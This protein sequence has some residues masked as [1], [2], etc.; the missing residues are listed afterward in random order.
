MGLLHAT[1]CRSW[2]FLLVLFVLASAPA[3]A[4]ID[5][6]QLP[7]SALWIKPHAQTL[8]EAELP[9]SVDPLAIWHSPDWVN[10]GSDEVFFFGFD[11]ASHW[12]RVPLIN[13]ST[14]PARALLEVAEPLY[15]D[16]RFWLIDNASGQLVLSAQ[17]GDRIPFHERPIPY[18]HPLIEVPLS[19]GQQATLLIRAHAMDGEHDPLPARL[20]SEPAFHAHAWTETW[21]Y[22]LYYGAIG[23]L[24]VYNLLIFVGTRERRFLWYGLFLSSFLLWNLTFRGYSHQYLWPSATTWNPIAIVWFSVGIYTLLAVF[25]WSLL[26]VRQRAPWLFRL[27]AILATVIGAHAIWIALDPNGGVFAT[28]DALGFLMLISLLVSGWR[29]AR[30]GLTVGWVYLAA[31]GCLF[32]GATAYYLVSFDLIPANVFTIHALNIGSVFEFVILALALA[33]R[34]NQLKDERNAAEQRAYVALQS[35]AQTLE[36]EVA[37]RTADLEAANQALQKLASIDSLTGLKNRRQFNQDLAA[38]LAQARRS[39]QP[40]GLMMID[41]DFFKRLNDA[42]GHLYG[43]E[44]LGRLGMLLRDQLRRQTDA[45]YRVGGEEFVVLAQATDRTGLMA[46]A[47]H[48]RAEIESAAWSHPAPGWSVVTVSIGCTTSRPEDTPEA[49]YD[50]ADKALYRA[51]SEGRNRCVLV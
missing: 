46:Q 47:E 48:L 50:R 15:D 22:G 33:W 17:A 5:L 38:A 14:A 4:A 24:L 11:H 45:A 35:A 34:I 51:K 41:V 40:L 20:W 1:R 43:D 12:V 7:S 16:L 8:R 25:T 18:R 27:Q 23:I 2:L 36:R 32:A 3:R 42:A 30:Q 31:N 28:L 10:A 44:V 29:V 9:N 21:V 13:T 49:L 37:Q 19:P 6:A 26:E 39:G